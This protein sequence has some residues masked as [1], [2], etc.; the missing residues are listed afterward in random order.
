VSQQFLKYFSTSSVAP[1]ANHLGNIDMYKANASTR[2]SYEWA[3][4]IIRS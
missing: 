2:H 1:F 4:Q 3:L